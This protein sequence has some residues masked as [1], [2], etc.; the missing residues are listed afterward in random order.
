M[1]ITKKSK[2]VPRAA[3]VATLCGIVD[4]SGVVSVFPE[5]GDDR[6][7]IEAYFRALIDDLE[8][9]P[10]ADWTHGRA[11]WKLNV[12]IFAVESDGIAIPDELRSA[13]FKDAADC[14]R[15]LSFAP[16]SSPVAYSRVRRTD[17][18]QWRFK[19]S[20]APIKEGRLD[21]IKKRL[22]LENE[23]SQV[24]EATSENT[25][26]VEEPNS[27]KINKLK[28]AADRVKSAVDAVLAKIAD[29]ASLD[30]ACD[31]YTVAAKSFAATILAERIR[32]SF[33]EK[34]DFRTG[35][36]NETA[37]QKY[38]TAQTIRDLLSPWNLGFCHPSKP[39]VVFQLFS[40][41]EGANG[42]YRL[43]GYG[44]ARKNSYR[45]SKAD[46]VVQIISAPELGDVTGFLYNHNLRDRS[47]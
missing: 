10:I 2:L 44:L 47:P 41:D 31:E 12:P 7:Y 38:Q 39:G 1:R 8:S 6:S 17:D 45:M 28:A 20:F 43:S 34:I 16:I 9:T 40:G 46:E 19:A 13:W 35:Q 21:V 18:H 24:S 33:L 30:E 26:P 25:L 14:I 27:A 37:E 29:E 32:Q 5:Q 11:Q 3:F 22:D 42:R 15:S 4:Q 23:L 36:S